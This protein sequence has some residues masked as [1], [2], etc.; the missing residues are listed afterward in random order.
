MP[1]IKIEANG[2]QL[3]S[4][5]ARRVIALT[6]VSLEAMRAH[7]DGLP[8]VC[9][10]QRD[11]LGDGEQVPARQWAARDAPAF[12]LQLRH[13]FEDRMLAAGVDERVRRDIMGHAL[14]RV[15]YGEGAS[16]EQQRDIIQAF[17]L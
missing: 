15:R 5:N 10:E 7:P 16:L 14:D 9:E 2:R 17:A 11:A 6:G 1:H 12:A 3:K 4:A 13:A 8:A